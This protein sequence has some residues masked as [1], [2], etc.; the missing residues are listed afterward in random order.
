NDRVHT[1]F[2][3][4]DRFTRE[5]FEI[6]AEGRT[7]SI[8]NKLHFRMLR[9]LPGRRM[10]VGISSKLTGGRIKI[11]FLQNV[12]NLSNDNGNGQDGTR[13]RFHQDGVAGNQTRINSRNGIPR[14]KSRT[15]DH[16]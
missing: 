9:K 13:M 2:F 1:R 7:A 4:E 16:Q 10:L 8:V 11:V 5:R 3:S 15:A 14:W 6:T 12:L